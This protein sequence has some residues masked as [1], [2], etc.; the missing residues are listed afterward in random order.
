MWDK[1]AQQYGDHNC[2]YLRSERPQATKKASLSDFDSRT[3]RCA[4][5]QPTRQPIG[6]R[7]RELN[8]IRH[9][10]RAWGAS[11]PGFFAFGRKGVN[12]KKYLLHV[13]SPGV[14]KLCL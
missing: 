8:A 12:A 11:V 10:V 2:R 13:T 3:W 7:V 5:W 14:V 6:T 1:S 9:N 4:L